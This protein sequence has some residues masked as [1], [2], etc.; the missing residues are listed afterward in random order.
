MSV[1]VKGDIS[2]ETPQ[3]HETCAARTLAAVSLYLSLTA[4]VISS[5]VAILVILSY[6]SPKSDLDKIPDLC[7][8][9]PDPGPCTSSV[10]RR[11]ERIRASWWDRASRHYFTVQVVSPAPCGGLCPVPLGRMSRQWQQLCQHWP[12]PGNM[13]GLDYR[14]WSATLSA[15]SI[16]IL[17]NP[18]SGDKNTIPAL[19]A[20][21]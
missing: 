10:N 5:V 3:Q 20:A 9:P 17:I 8:L 11:D 18:S 6:F 2:K 13:Q 12:V 16:I 14:R 4:L 19:L 7:L 1:S 21:T 15:L